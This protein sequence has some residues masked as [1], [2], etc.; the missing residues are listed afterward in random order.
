MKQ[1]R[2]KLGRKLIGFLLTLAMVVGLMP[3]MGLTAYAETTEYD[4]YF[5]EVEN[6][7]QNCV[8]AGICS[9]TEGLYCKG[10]SADVAK[11]AC[12]YLKSKTGSKVAVVYG[13]AVNTRKSNWSKIYIMVDGSPVTNYYGDAPIKSIIGDDCKLFYVKSDAPDFETVS[14]TVTFKVLNGQWDDGTTEDVTVIL[15]GLKDTVYLASDQIPAVGASPSDTYKAGSWDTPPSTET[16]IT[17]DTTYTYT[18]EKKEAAVVTKAPEAKTLTYN[19]QAQELITAGEATGGEMQYALG[20]ETEATDHYTASLP[21]A[22]DAG[23]YYVWYKV[24]GDENHTDTEPMSLK[25]TIS[26]KGDT[27]IKTEVKKDDK[28][29]EIK[30]SNLTDEFA[31][32]TLSNEEKAAIEEAIN[33]GEDVKVDVYLEIENISDAISASDK[34]KI[35]ASATNADNIAFFDISLFK[36][37]SISGQSQGAASVHNL[38]TPLKLTIGVPKSFPAVADGYTRTYAVLRLHDGSVTVLPTTLNAD[39]TLSFETDKFS[40]YAL[41]YT[42]VKKEETKEP[43]ADTPTTT[44]DTPTTKV[45]TPTVNADTPKAEAKNTDNKI[46]TGD[47]MNIGIIIM[48]MVDSAM[49]ALYLTLRKKMIK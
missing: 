44:V 5:V 26:D 40:T 47:K 37:I 17:K 32:S 9:M 20:T 34:E 3:G 18:Y 41:A 25:V 29:P 2:K 43:T 6:L 4:N 30:T 48:L 46:S 21:T 35:E 8:S 49:A 42:D 7:N 16:A 31:E 12:N 45:D 11:A 33:N 1:K 36:E 15:G 38:T 13:F 19:G 23:T 22:T 39:G 14:A 10:L 24:V 27:E 28:S